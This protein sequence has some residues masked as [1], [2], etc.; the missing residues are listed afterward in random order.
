MWFRLPVPYNGGLNSAG[1]RRKFVS[2][3]FGNAGYGIPKVKV[4][5]FQLDG[6]EATVKPGSASCFKFGFIWP[7]P[8]KSNPKPFRSV[9]IPVVQTLGQSPTRSNPK[10]GIRPNRFK[11][12]LVIPRDPH[13]RAPQ[14]LIC[15]VTE[16]KNPVR[17]NSG[18]HLIRYPPVSPQLG[19][20]EVNLP[21][22]LKGRTQSGLP[23]KAI[24]NAN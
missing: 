2:L 3:K 15:E 4:P 12:T 6:P 14:K 22:L 5:M 20:T 9:L 21:R 24:S 13:R 8:T 10:K 1:T 23:Y 11:T 18:V 17:L 7:R 16:G 19:P